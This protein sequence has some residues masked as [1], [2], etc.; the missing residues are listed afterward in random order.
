MF[1]INWKYLSFVNGILSYDGFEGGEDRVRF[2]HL[3]E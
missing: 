3:S 1:G 2:S